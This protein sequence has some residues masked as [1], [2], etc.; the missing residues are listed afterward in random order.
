LPRLSDEALSARA[1]EM[2]TA[3][4]SIATSSHP[5]IGPISNVRLRLDGP[6]ASDRSADRY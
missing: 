3:A 5:S 1:A 6:A 2:V 4:A